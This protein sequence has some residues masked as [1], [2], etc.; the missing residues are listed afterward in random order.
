MTGRE[1]G[2]DATA[3]AGPTAAP[4]AAVPSA[5]AAVS[6][7]SSA[8]GATFSNECLLQHGEAL[9]P[10]TRGA[11]TSFLDECA[12][13]VVRTTDA[14]WRPGLDAASVN[15]S[16]EEYFYEGWQSVSSF[17]RQYQG[18]AA[19][20]D[21]VW[22]TKRAFPDL[23][24]HVTDVFCTG[25]DVDGYK[26]AMPDV[27]TGTNTGPSAFGPPTGR[28]VAYNGV[29]LCYVQRVKGRW[30][31]VSEVVVHDEA[32]L[33]HQLGVTNLTAAMHP[34]TVA[35]PHDCRTNRPTWGWAAQPSSAAA[36]AAAPPSLAAATVAA[37]VE[38]AAA[39][40]TTLPTPNAE[41]RLGWWVLGIAGQLLAL[42]V[43]LKL[44]AAF[45]ATLYRRAT[46]E[47]Q[48]VRACAS[49][50]EVYLRMPDGS[51]AAASKSDRGPW[52]GAMGRE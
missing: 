8:D 50:E 35:S 49:A 26:T 4:S 25:N 48:R 38:A 45:V 37:V 22:R 32:A 47:R 18:M 42:G 27:L 40:T 17:G 11:P 10:P 1:G 36:G 31:Y 39:A 3:A 6:A 34:D 16:L 23:Q 20:K 28:K 7:T 43:A 19:L 52:G 21:L 30:Q 9:Q 2:G 12:A 13:W 33:M 46:E 15:A 44:S 41:P 51:G 29:A 24:I 5:A 14:V